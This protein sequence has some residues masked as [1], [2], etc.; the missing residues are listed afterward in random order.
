M[1]VASKA[2]GR[3][4]AVAEW[5]TLLVIVLCWLTYGLLTWFWQDL[6]WWIVTP[7]GAYVLCLYGSL[8]HEVVHGHPTRSAL[9]NETL[10]HLP[11]GLMFPFRR[12]KATHQAHHDTDHLTYPGEDPES[13]YLDPQACN[14][15]C[16]ARK[17]ML[18]ANNSLIGRLTIG[19]AITV[20]VFLIS[21]VKLILGGDRQVGLVWLVHGLGIAAVWCWVGLVCGMP[22]WLYV[23]GIAYWGLSLTLLRSYAEHRA[24]DEASCRT[25]IVET[26]PL[27]SLMFLNNNLHMAHH[28]KPG[29]AWYRLPAYYRQNKQRLIRDN[30]GYLMNGYGELLRR[31]GLKPKEPLAHPLPHSLKRQDA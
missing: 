13:N 8:Q 18:T 12:Y 24:H 25:I 7:A 14:R 2:T 3:P 29:L 10:V 22:F 6:G 16:L 27:I 26:N 23:A 15:M 31:F 11:I 17:W 9:V 4:G 28:E 20:A 21:E 30:C 19:P 5:P 1:A